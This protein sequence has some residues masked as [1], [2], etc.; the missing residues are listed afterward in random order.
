MTRGT[1]GQLVGCLWQNLFK[2][3]IVGKEISESY[4][5]K[6]VASKTLGL[7]LPGVFTKICEHVLGSVLYITFC[8]GCMTS[9]TWH[10]VI[11]RREIN[12]CNQASHAP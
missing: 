10:T 4:N 9:A 7:C 5:I 3:K 2:W 6:Y 11:C 12:T 8:L 1:Y